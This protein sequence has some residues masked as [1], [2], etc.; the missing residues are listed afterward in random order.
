M[1]DAGRTNGNIHQGDVAMEDV[2]ANASKRKS[3]TS[4][5]QRKSY[6]EPESSEDDQP[7]V[8]LSPERQ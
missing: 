7:L 6:A 1:K 8:R 4:V 3:R 2:D 5:G